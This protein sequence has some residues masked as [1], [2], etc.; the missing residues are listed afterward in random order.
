MFRKSRDEHS[1]T[2]EAFFRFISER[3]REARRER[4]KS[5]QDLAHF[6]Y[7]TGKVISDIER[8]RVHVDL[9]DLSLI[10]EALDKPIS[11]FF[12]PFLT[13]G[14]EQDLSPDERELLLFYRK[15]WDDKLRIAALEQMRGI[16]KIDIQAH[17][18]QIRDEFEEEQQSQDPE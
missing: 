14:S 15:I 7:K 6:L 4:S 17:L 11:Y 10:A 18:D 2:Q 12:P 1:H 9:F 13:E 16:A 3:I 5:Q 8:G